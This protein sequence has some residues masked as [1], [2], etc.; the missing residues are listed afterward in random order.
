M[1]NDCKTFPLARAS[2]RGD[3]KM[4]NLLIDLGAE[5]DGRDGDSMTP[6]MWAVKRNHINIVTCLI[7]RGANP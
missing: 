1:T 5:I 6:I 3:F 7:A 4:V 2:W